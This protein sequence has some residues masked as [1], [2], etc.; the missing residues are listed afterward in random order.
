MFLSVHAMIW[1]KS[2]DRQESFY[3]IIYHSFSFCGYIQDYKF[4]MGMEIV[5]FA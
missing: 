2:D 1:C 3:H 4:H 5:I